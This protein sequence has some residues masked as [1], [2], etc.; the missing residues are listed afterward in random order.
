MVSCSLFLFSIC[1]LHVNMVIGW[2]FEDRQ[3]EAHRCEISN[4]SNWLGLCGLHGSRESFRTSREQEHRRKMVSPRPEGLFP[5]NWHQAG[6]VDDTRVRAQKECGYG[7]YL[8]D[9]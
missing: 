1:V 5:A 3:S 2:R 9:E 7:K 8:G 4:L 6:D